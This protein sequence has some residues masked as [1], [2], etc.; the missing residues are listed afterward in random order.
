KVDLTYQPIYRGD[1]LVICSDGLS[2]QVKKE[3]IAELV[4]ASTELT[5]LCA[6]L[7]DLANER[8]G[9]DNI[10][11]VAARFEGDGLPE[12]TG[13][14]EMGYQVYP[15]V[16]GEAT[17]QPVPVYTGSPAPVPIGDGSAQP[18]PRWVL[19]GAA[20]LALAVLLYLVTAR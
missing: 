2:G 11:A 9:P 4:A 19:I 18:R 1:T 13:D 6:Q 10:T 20:L 3:E 5:A 7:I 17:T 12:P 16:E 15:L 8:G 14:E